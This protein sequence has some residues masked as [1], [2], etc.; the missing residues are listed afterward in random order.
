MDVHVPL[1]RQRDEDSGR[2]K[3]GRSLG[4]GMAK[5]SAPARTDVP[6]TDFDDCGKK[7]IKDLAEANTNGSLMGS[8][9]HG[10]ANPASVK[11]AIYDVVT[12]QFN[13]ELS[14]EEAV[15]ELVAAVEAAK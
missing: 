6:D 3:T 9:A 8:M 12:R 11:N 5:G 4:G 2:S 13:G 1:H 14:S 10:H 15:T 7:A